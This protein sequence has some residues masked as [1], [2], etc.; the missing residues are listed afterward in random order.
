MSP[1]HGDPI[2]PEPHWKQLQRQVREANAERTDAEFRIGQLEARLHNLEINLVR[3]LESLTAAYQNM[4]K[5]L[6]L[7]VTRHEFD[8]LRLVV[9]GLCLI[10]LVGVV[11]SGRVT[12][13]RPHQARIFGDT[14]A[15]AASEV[16]PPST[17]RSTPV[18]K[19]DSS[20]ARKTAA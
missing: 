7:L 17:G 13:L 5:S 19:P 15:E 20:Q 11:H 2:A 8:P 9:Y 14:T 4:A 6:D 10:V 3:Q 12:G 16:T 18:I 1:L